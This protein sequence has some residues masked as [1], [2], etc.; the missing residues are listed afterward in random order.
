V[1]LTRPPLPHPPVSLAFPDASLRSGNHM[2]EDPEPV[3]NATGGGENDRESLIGRAFTILGVIRDSG[4]PL[5]FSGVVRRTG[6]PKSTVHRL[7]AE[8]RAHDAV[9]RTGGHYELGAAALRLAAPRDTARTRAIRHAVKPLLV[10]LHANTHH[11]VGLGVRRG[12]T[13]EF[14]DLVYTRRYSRLACAWGEAADLRASAAGRV[15]L[16]HD[17]E[18]ARAHGL[19]L[20]PG[21]CAELA[22]IRRSGVAVLTDAGAVAMAVPLFGD[23]ERPLA[24]LSVAAYQGLFDRAATYDL[25]RRA[26][27]H[28]R[29]VLCRSLPEVGPD[30]GADRLA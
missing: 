29:A 15:L 11:L 17:R 9:S 7:L 6:L 20:S 30:R 21:L 26:S 25:L 3:G 4:E 28:A 2:P 5:T 19:D 24:A 22:R 14:I 27:F 18:P 12:A 10:A 23:E 8:L 13:V 1:H 16:A